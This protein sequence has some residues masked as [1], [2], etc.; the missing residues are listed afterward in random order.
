MECPYCGSE[1]ESEVYSDSDGD[2]V[3]TRHF[4]TADLLRD[5]V[6]EETCE[7]TAEDEDRLIAEAVEGYLANG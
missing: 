4:W 7:W 5:E 2:G 1:V 3:Y 6:C